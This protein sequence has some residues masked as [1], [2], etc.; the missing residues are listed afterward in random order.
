MHGSLDGKPLEVDV[1]HSM[2][3][4]DSYHNFEMMHL[5]TGT[6]QWLSYVE[7]TYVHTFVDIY[8]HIYRK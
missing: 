7:H 2:H 5:G 1:I 8:N 3:F 6:L 4:E